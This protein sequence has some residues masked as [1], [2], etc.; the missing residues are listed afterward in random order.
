MA[1]LL[2][3]KLL[4]AGVAIGGLLL[5]LVSG[6]VVFS[7]V[8]RV[9]PVSWGM[10]GDVNHSAGVAIDGYDV[11]AYRRGGPVVGSSE[12]SMN[13]AGTTWYFSSEENL[14][15]FAVA[16]A[17]FAPQFGG[18]CSYAVSKGFTAASNPTVFAL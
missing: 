12:H 1:W 5:A 11:M 6:V 8:K 9:A 16:P 15:A 10:Y 13:Y 2:D 3:N 14:G 18:Y 17:T 7:N 4:V